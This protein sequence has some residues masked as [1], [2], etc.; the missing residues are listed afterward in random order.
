[1]LRGRKTLAGITSLSSLAQYEFIDSLKAETSL[2]EISWSGK[3]DARRLLTMVGSCMYYHRPHDRAS[4]GPHGMS[5]FRRRTI[6]TE[7][8]TKMVVLIYA[9]SAEVNS[10][11]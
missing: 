6:K 9:G 11:P 1:M 3:P 4:F 5:D 2:G 8:V 10:R 7:I